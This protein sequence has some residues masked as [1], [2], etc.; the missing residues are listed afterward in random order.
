MIYIT[1]QTTTRSTLILRRS[2]YLFETIISVFFP[3]FT[4]KTQTILYRFSR[5]DRKNTISSSAFKYISPAA[6]NIQISKRNTCVKR[7]Q[8]KNNNN[9]IFFSF[10]YQ[11][12]IRVCFSTNTYLFVIFT[13]VIINIYF[14]NQTNSVL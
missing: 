13:K 9:F 4:D 12:E 1:T 5:K 3:I 10:N 8:R 7:I 11:C 2:I 14:F 6:H